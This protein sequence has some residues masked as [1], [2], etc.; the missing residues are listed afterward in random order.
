[1]N[2]QIA[3]NH[4]DLRT[5][6][7][8]N[9][10][11]ADF[12]ILSQTVHGKPL[13]YLD[14]AATTQKPQ[15]VIAAVDNY[16]REYNANIHRGVHSLS[17]KATTAYEDARAT[18]RRFI[19]A[20]ASEEIIFVRGATEGINLIAQ[21]YG[22]S[23]LRAGDE[24]IISEMEHHSNIVPWQM[25]CE[26]TGAVLK[27]IP[28]DENGDLILSGYKKLLGPKTRIV[29]IVHTSNALGT[30]N[31]VRQIIEQ[32]H[33]HNA[34]VVV[35]GAQAVAHAPVDVTSLDCDFYV[36]SGHKLFAPTGTGVVYGKRD[37][38]EKMPPYQG[39]GDMIKV[40]TF[41]K[42]RYNDLPYKF[43][44]GTPHIAG[45]IG[46]GKAIEYIEAIGLENIA[47][48]EKELLDYG[49]RAI[50]DVPGL[51]LIG[52]AIHKTS[53]LSFT[54]GRVHPHDIGTILDHEGIAVRAGHHCAMPV[55]EHFRVPATARASLAFYNTC[56]EIDRL[57]AGLHKCREMF[58]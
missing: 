9:A 45:V 44:A 26:Q 55:M 30:I 4:G 8:V 52:T 6:F 34:V 37:L 21:S 16:Y 58:S 47:V 53:I 38:L 24:I 41:E 20:G 3:E 43:E 5:A 18:V 33:A 49:S 51:R 17:E 35:D 27:V 36:F 50:L 31:P 10:V 32:A 23:N 2:R 15:S 57:V 42:T 22:R 46:L 14:N 7:D 12:P 48:H 25:L 29:S 11:R 1:M 39:G 28:M 54:L 13:A 56:A 40:V 19:N